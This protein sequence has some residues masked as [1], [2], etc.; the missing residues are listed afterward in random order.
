[1]ENDPY[2]LWIHGLENMELGLD[3]M[4]RGIRMEIRGA[5]E[6]AKRLEKKC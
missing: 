1:M 2:D 6:I 5:K 3:K 4:L